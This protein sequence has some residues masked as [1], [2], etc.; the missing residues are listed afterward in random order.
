M[1]ISI[2]NIAFVIL[3]AAVLLTACKKENYPSR[4]TSGLKPPPP[5]PPPPP[6]DPTLVSFNPA[7]AIDNWESAGNKGA[8][9]KTGGKEGSRGPSRGHLAAILLLKRW[10]AANGDPPRHSI[11][12]W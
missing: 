11:A 2:T 4:D 7:D 1:K 12:I 8:I 9:E 10:H 3:L 6:P 5:P